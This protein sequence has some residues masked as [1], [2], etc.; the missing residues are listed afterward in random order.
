[1]QMKDFLPWARAAGGGSTE[2]KAQDE[3]NP[4]AELQRQMN[5]VFEN[6]WRGA[7]RPF[8]A[9]GLPWGDGMPR[10][11]VVETEDAVEISVELPGMDQKDVEVSLAGDT[12]TIKGEKKIERQDE[13]RGYYLSERSYGSV[14]RSIP[15]P[16]GVD[17]DKAEATF[18]NGV[19]TVRLPQ[20]EEA[21]Q[22]VKRVDVKAA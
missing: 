9:A 10:S 12:L 3:S 14:Y 16:P 2:V 5:S 13:K 7:D 4:V 8:G 17:P 11:D 19:L 21:K 6:F 20:T 1:M 18:R 15:L 22:K